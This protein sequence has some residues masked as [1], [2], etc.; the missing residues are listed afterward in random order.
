MSTRIPARDGTEEPARPRTKLQIPPAGDI[1]RQSA[2]DLAAGIR[3]R[4]FSVREVAAAF[5]ERIEAVNPLVNAI[6][7]LRDPADVLA[8]AEAADA[9]L[10]RG[11]PT[12]SLFGLPIAIKDLALTT[13]LKTTFGSPIFADFVPDEDDIFVERMRR[14]G[15]IFIGKTN[16]PEFGLG[17]N[18]YNPVFGPTLNAFDPAWTAG[19]SSGGAAGAPAL[20]TGP[21]ADGR[22]FRGSRREPPAQ[23]NQ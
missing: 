17:S 18:T 10:V 6:V 11:E 13:G 15:A 12:G 3:R 16:V 2:T 22:N 9:R 7:S 19:G 14:A 23:K 8:E 1:C 21:G 20:H 4:D 5:L